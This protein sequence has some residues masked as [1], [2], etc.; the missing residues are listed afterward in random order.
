MNDMRWSDC[1]QIFF[2]DGY[3][4]GLKPNLTTIYLGEE[5]D[6]GE[7]L[8]TGKVW[9]ATPPI[10]KQV[11]ND[12]LE[13]RK[14]LELGN[15]GTTD[16]ERD[17]TSGTSRHREENIRQIKKRGRVPIHQINRKKQGVSA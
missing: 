13:Y 12:I 11:L 4:Y 14:E 7:M 9:D 5:A 15:T 2:I 10:R 1:G 6:I 16:M 17:G 8:K 3:G